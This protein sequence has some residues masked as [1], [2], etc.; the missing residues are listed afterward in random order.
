LLSGDES[1]LPPPPVAAREHPASPRDAMIDEA[2]TNSLLV[3]FM[4]LLPP[5]LPG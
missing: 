1:L 4:P 2:V 3:R 5:S